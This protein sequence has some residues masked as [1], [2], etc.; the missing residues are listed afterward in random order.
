MITFTVT[1]RL[2]LYMYGNYLVI[3]RSGMSFLVFST[4]VQQTTKFL[5][6]SKLLKVF[7]CHHH[8]RLFSKLLLSICIKSTN[9]TNFDYFLKIY[10]SRKQ[11]RLSLTNDLGRAGKRW[12]DAPPIVNI[13]LFLSCVK[14]KVFIFKFPT[15]KTLAVFDRMVFEEN[16]IIK[17][18]LLS[19]LKQFFS[20]S[21]TPARKTLKQSLENSYEIS[22]NH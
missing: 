14:I 10:S 17:L 8:L 6:I 18:D 4:E 16:H 2:Q 11:D 21:L 7:R 1:I 9:S 3:I 13:L 20:K 12:F 19:V 15:K 5:V 22:T